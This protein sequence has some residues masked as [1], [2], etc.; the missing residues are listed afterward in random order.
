MG[1][2]A[3][4]RP[5]PDGSRP[6]LLHG[7]TGSA[8]TW[9]ATILEGLRGAGFAPQ[10]VDL[11]GHGRRRGDTD[12]EHF[13][14]DAVLASIDEVPSV[15]PV[16]G[17]SMGGRIALHYAL[18]RPGRLTRL[19]LESASPGLDDERERVERRNED[20]ALAE[21]LEAEGIGAFVDRW[22][23]MP[24][25]ASHERL[26]DRVRSALREGRLANDPRSLAAALRGLGTGRLPSL[27]ERLGNLRVPVLLLVGELDTKFVAI[28]ERMAGLLPDAR[29]VV[30][31]GAGHTVHLERPDA[32]LET[33]VGFLGPSAGHT[34]RD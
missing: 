6:L 32:W 4:S 9:G 3:S 25:F 31:P 34:G 21:L 26:A 2:L 13:S 18:R 33:V 1:S 11:P 16:I 23:R 5:P 7:F 8:R 28:G 30:V 10:A 22:E 19:V 27:S 15:G 24:L 29:L 12:P 17:Y 20:E 14:L